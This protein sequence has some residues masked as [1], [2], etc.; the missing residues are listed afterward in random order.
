MVHKR[1]LPEFDMDTINGTVNEDGMTVREYLGNHIRE[2]RSANSYLT[3]GFWTKLYQEFPLKEE[4]LRGVT[5]LLGLLEN[6]TYASNLCF[7]YQRKVI[8]RNSI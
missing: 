3:T 7:G 8:A 2:N 5:R 4:T 6:I 1:L